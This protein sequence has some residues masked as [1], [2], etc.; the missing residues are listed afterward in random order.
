MKIE[1]TVNAQGG[2]DVRI[3]DK[4]VGTIPPITGPTPTLVDTAHDVNTR[5]LH[6]FSRCAANREFCKFLHFH[7]DCA[8][9]H[10]TYHQ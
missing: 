7:V 5:E 10:S 2:Y 4:D 3:N 6:V 9:I 1:V 8:A